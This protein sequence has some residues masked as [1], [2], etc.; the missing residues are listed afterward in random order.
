[1][2]AQTPAD[3]GFR[4]PAEWD[5]HERTWMVFPGTR[6]IGPNPKDQQDPELRR[7][8]EIWV[9]IAN[10]I[11]RY[12][13]VTMLADPV[14][15]SL[16]RS[17]LSERVSIEERPVDDAWMRDVG[18]TFLTDGNGELAATGWTFNGWGQRPWASAH[19]SRHHAQQ[20]AE[21]ARAHFFTSPLVN[22]GGAIHVD[23]EGT[24]LLTTTVQLDP[25]RNPGWTKELV[26]QEVHAHLGT[27]K[28]IWV[29]RGLTA[30]YA[31]YSTRGHIDLLAAFVAP[32]VVVVHDQDDP[33][34]PD[35][36]VSQETLRLLQAATDAQG[37][38]LRV[39]PLPAPHVQYHSDG[40]L[41]DFTYLNHYLANG[42]VI[43]CAFDDPRD[44]EAAQV[45][46][47][48]FPERTVELVD[49]RGIFPYGG[50]IHCITQQQPT[51]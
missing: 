41:A 34:H 43:L 29:P 11:A 35:H 30:D 6:S 20:V 19:H 21:L 8:R 9:R 48:L 1:M 37:R 14:D 25:H 5:P 40:E 26:E 17:L 16:A 15:A 45:F 12:E 44:E 32:G 39:I 46:Q 2:S 4:M 10:T 50:A 49:C 36:T 24:V 18:P 33:T 51:P 27:R 13:P 3:L 7:C 38:P 22:E 28:A 47:D 31:G 42:A 23:G